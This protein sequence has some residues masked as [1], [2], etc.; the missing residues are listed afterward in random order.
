MMGRSVMPELI[1][2]VP[3]LAFAGLVIATVLYFV[4][5]RRRG[6]VRH[7]R[8]ADDWDRQVSQARAIQRLE[9]MEKEDRDR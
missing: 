2:I 6:H 1:I 9:H 3:A 8:R 5:V 4:M 7:V